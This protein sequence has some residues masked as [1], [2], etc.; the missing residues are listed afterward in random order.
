M[1]ISADDMLL[2]A[3][4]NLLSLARLCCVPLVVWLILVRRFDIA[5]GVFMLAGV[6]DAIDG[7]IAKRFDA[8]T[9]LGKFIDPLADKALLVSVYITLAAVGSMPTWLVILVVFR[10]VLIV[11]G[12]LLIHTMRQKIVMNPLKISKLNTVAQIVLAGVIMLRDGYDVMPDGIGGFLMAVVAATT[13]LSGAAYVWVWR[14]DI[15]GVGEKT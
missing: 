4:P 2:V 3:I 6:T 10:D 7:F 1:A 14:R 5:L 12:S 13:F 8:V 9:E 11:G 15:T